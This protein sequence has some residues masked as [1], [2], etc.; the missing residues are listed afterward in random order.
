MP[1]TQYYGS[2]E[3]CRRHSRH[4]QQCQRQQQR[5]CWLLRHERT[6]GRYE[7]RRGQ[8]TLRN[9]LTGS[10]NTIVG[11]RAAN[12]I[13]ST[14]NTALGYRALYKHYVGRFNVALGSE[15]GYRDWQ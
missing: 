4:E 9:N 2:R 10:A 3:C 14:G 15:A 11:Y 13:T 6:P 1:G 5:G 8:R 12:N 7:C